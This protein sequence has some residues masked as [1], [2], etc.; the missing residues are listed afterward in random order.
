MFLYR[1]E[2]EIHYPHGLK[3]VIPAGNRWFADTLSLLIKLG[4]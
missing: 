3:V 1:T 4:E 2:I